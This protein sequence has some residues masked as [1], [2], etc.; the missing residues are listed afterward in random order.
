MCIYCKIDAEN[1][2]NI[3]LLENL[4]IYANK[5][6]PESMNKNEDSGDDGN[7]ILMFKDYFYY[8][9]LGAKI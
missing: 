9:F 2:V 1:K 6:S 7:I 3:S 8:E 4:L 5:S